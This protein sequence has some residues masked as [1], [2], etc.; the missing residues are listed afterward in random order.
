MGSGVGV[1]VGAAFG[2]G[3][4]FEGRTRPERSVAVRLSSVRH[5]WQRVSS[6]HASHAAALTLGKSH[7]CTV[8]SVLPLTQRTGSERKGARAWL[9]LGLRLGLGLG[10]GFGLEFGLGLA[11]RVCAWLG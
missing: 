3:F 11:Y 2:F 9:V 1:G 8:R 7:P 6:V 4:T 10:L 5:P